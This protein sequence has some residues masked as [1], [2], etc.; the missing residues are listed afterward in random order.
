MQMLTNAYDA[1]D[2]MDVTEE[3]IAASR[4]NRLTEEEIEEMRGIARRFQESARNSR[5]GENTEGEQ[6]ELLWKLPVHVSIDTQQDH[7]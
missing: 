2:A 1:Q 7:N 4:K 3:R 6:N 5:R